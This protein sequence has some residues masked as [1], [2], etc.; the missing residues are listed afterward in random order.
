[1]HLRGVVS[2]G[3]Y[4]SP[5]LQRGIH[6]LKFRGVRPCAQPL[7]ALLTDRLLAIAPLAVLAHHATLVPIPL[8]WRKRRARGFNQSADLAQ[9]LTELTGI[10][11]SDVLER[12]RST[13]TQ[14]KLPPTLRN[15]NLAGAFRLREMPPPARYILLVDDVTTTG[16]TLAAAAS[17]WD[18]QAQVWGVTVARG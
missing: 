2:A 13:W 3:S 1:M 10:P 12:Q 14:S 6:W 5:L 4:S 18:T 11:T 17:A 16:A 15:Q 8:H 9:A 7:A